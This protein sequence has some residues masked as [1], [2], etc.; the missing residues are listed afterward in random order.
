MPPGL[1]S[2]YVGFFFVHLMLKTDGFSIFHALTPTVAQL[3]FY[4][5]SSSVNF[6]FKG[7]ND[8]SDRIETAYIQVH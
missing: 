5:H 7:L 6:N 1:L 4:E 8:A 3:M 2:L